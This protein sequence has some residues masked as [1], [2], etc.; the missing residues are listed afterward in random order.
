MNQSLQTTNTAETAM[1]DPNVMAKRIQL[2]QQLMKTVMRN[3]VH[4]GTIPGCGKPSLWLPGAQVLKVSFKLGTRYS[5][6]DLSTS[7]E[8]C[9]RVTA[10]VFDQQ[11]GNILGYG[12]GECSSSEE[13]YAWRKA[14]CDEEFEATPE[15]EKREKY[16]KGYGGSFYTVKQIRTNPSDVSNTILKMATKRA[17][18]HGTINATGASDVF[19]QDIEDLPEGYNFEESG[20]SSN[21]PSVSPDDIHVSESGRHQSLKL[22]EMVRPSDEERKKCCL[23]SEKQVYFMYGKCKESGVE[24]MAVARAAKVQNPFWLT[25]KK[26]VKTNFD[27]MLKVVIEKPSSFSKY[28]DAALTSKEAPTSQDSEQVATV[29]DQE[30]FCQLVTSLSLQS[31]YS[32]ENGLKEVTGVDHPEDVLPEDQQKCIDFFTAKAETPA[33]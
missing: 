29:M 18:I 26:S 6:E 9:F 5:V 15:T 32:L 30:E 23:V 1:V 27:A 22:D 16:Q 20:F 19:T 12:V 33:A 14:I 8:K 3:N 17:D 31:G 11:T 13:K 10:E 24:I 21:K 25:W 2:M 7:F 28:S 4:Y